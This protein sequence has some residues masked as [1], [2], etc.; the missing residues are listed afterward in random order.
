MVVKFSGMIL[1]VLLA[2]NAVA[3]QERFGGRRCGG[4]G[5]WRGLTEEQERGIGFGENT[6]EVEAVN[7]PLDAQNVDEAL[8]NAGEEQ[9]K[10]KMKDSRAWW[11][12]NVEYD[13]RL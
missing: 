10:K 4:F 12:R 1:V 3:A 9:A 2:T 7:D 11:D 13:R 8:N 5:R 6:Q